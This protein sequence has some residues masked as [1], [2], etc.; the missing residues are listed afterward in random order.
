MGEY[1]NK[2]KIIQSQGGGWRQGHSGLTRQVA[3]KKYP[4]INNGI[5]L[6]CPI[7]RLLKDKNFS[8]EIPLFLL[9]R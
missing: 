5:Y 8:S 6:S 9:M 3:H 2:Y 4:A 7:R 1:E